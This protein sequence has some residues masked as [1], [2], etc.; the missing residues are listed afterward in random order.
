MLDRAGRPE[1]GTGVGKSLAYLL[2]AALHALDSGRKAV[3][4]THTINL[5]E[6]LAGKDLPLLQKAMDQPLAWAL[7]KG[8]GNYV[9]IRRALLATRPRARAQHNHSES[10]E[11]SNSS[12]TSAEARNNA[13]GPEVAGRAHDGRS[14]TA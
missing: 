14:R 1:A 4:S 7:V 3:I 12:V 10:M 13:R 9:S 6:Q 8:R 11:K 2:P 5:Q